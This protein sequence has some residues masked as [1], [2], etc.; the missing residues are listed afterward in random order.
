MVVLLAIVVGPHGRLLELVVLSSTTNFRSLS[1]L[2]CPLQ[3]KKLNVVTSRHLWSFPLE[4]PHFYF[5]FVSPTCRAWQ[6]ENQVLLWGPTEHQDWDLPS[7]VFLPL[8]I[9]C[10]R[11]LFHISILFIF[12]F[13]SMGAGADFPFAV[14][15]LI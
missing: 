14:S 7:L 13:V 3:A 9:F 1:H 12:P 11:N 5:I 10:P 4:V 2:L 8:S 6:R 15:R